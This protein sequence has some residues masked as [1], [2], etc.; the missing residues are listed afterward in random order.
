MPDVIL[1]FIIKVYNRSMASLCTWNASCLMNIII[2]F[3]AETIGITSSLMV[4]V[5]TMVM[6]VMMVF[7]ARRST[8]SSIDLVCE[9]VISC[10]E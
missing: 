8:A 5:V 6:V 4:M 9:I 1:R 2:L 10:Y 7:T 3:S